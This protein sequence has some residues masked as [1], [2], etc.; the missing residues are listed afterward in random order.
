MTQCDYR[1]VTVVQGRGRE[2]I[3]E[4]SDDLIQVK[5][6]ETKHRKE[7]KETMRIHFKMTR[8]IIKQLT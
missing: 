8:H 1:S 7:N 3:Q 2:R 5:K 6:T 4:I